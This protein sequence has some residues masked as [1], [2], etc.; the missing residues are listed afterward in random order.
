MSKHV[1]YLSY[2]GITDALGQSQVL[3]YL[4][5]LAGKGFNVH[6]ISTE[7]KYDKISFDK[8]YSELLNSNIYWYPVQYHKS[9]PII[10]TL[11]DIRNIKKKVRELIHK[12]PIELIHCRGYITGL[13]GLHFK[14]KKNIP[15]LFDMRG[16]FADERA[17]SGNWNIKNPLYKIIYNWFKKKE[18][19]LFEK[20]DHIIS[21]TN[22]GKEI[23]STQILPGAENKMDI[24]PCCVDLKKFDYQ[25][26]E[27]ESVSLKNELGI[28]PNSKI[29]TYLG[30]IGTWY[31]PEEMIDFFSLLHKRIPES[32][33]LFVTNEPTQ[34]IDHLLTRKNVDKSIFFSTSQPAN[35]VPKYLG[36]SDWGLF[37]IKTLFSKKVSSPTK[38][39]EFLAMGIPVITNSGIGDVDELIINES[40]G[41]L[42][43]DFSKEC[44]L[45]A[46]EKIVSFEKKPA[47][48]YRKI[49]DQNFNVEWGI[50]KYYS[51]YQK[52]M[53]K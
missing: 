7:K 49:A 45:E 36:I 46:I 18:I 37:F 9:P 17:E 53:N 3:P 35:L 20:A 22:K 52:I 16:L 40:A 26:V 12:Y 51:V 1:L 11:W 23:I 41:I 14:I 13:V 28:S 5:G 29:F 21:L 33:F 30:S 31:L 6:L 43:N 42:I 47:S 24:I 39:A 25:L 10:S 34:V 19:T 8:L 4:K 15:Y 2:D 32:V 48:F 50:E 27:N 38:L 44:Y